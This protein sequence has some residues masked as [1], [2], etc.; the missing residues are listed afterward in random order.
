MSVS[1]LCQAFEVS[2]VWEYCKR[3]AVEFDRHKKAGVSNVLI[4][5]C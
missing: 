2:V 5:K 4:L 3:E 1:C